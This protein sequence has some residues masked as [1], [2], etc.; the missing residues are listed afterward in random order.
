MVGFW[1]GPKFEANV[2]CLNS[3]AGRQFSRGTTPIQNHECQVCWTDSTCEDLGSMGMS[4]HPETMPQLW[5]NCP[6]AS[7]E[8]SRAR[9]LE[10]ETPTENLQL[11]G[12]HSH[13]NPLS[14]CGE[15]FSLK[16]EIGA[17]ELMSTISI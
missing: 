7:E 6:R 3:S 10:K 8:G 9:G 15:I 12:R 14:H 13:L 4:V 2:R 11:C 17:R 1:G 16:S 5:V